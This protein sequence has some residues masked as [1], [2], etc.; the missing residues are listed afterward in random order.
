MIP[1]NLWLDAPTANYYLRIDF[2]RRDGLYC[3]RWQKHGQLCQLGL[4]YLTH[5]NAQR[6]FLEREAEFIDNP[7]I[8]DWRPS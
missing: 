3:S 1:L 2:V 4:A 7:G 5:E 6:S 8:P